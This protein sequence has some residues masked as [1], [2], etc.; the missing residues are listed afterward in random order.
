MKKSAQKQF[1]KE[2]LILIFCLILGFALRFYTFDQ[3]SLWM[4]EIYTFEDS[5]YDLKEQL[6]FYKEN[7]TYVQAPLFFILTHQLYPFEKPER[8][9]R[10]IP[11]IFG[12][13]SIPM[14]Y[15]LARQFSSTIA[16]PCSLSLALMTYHVSLSQDARSYTFLM[17]IG[18]VGLFFFM[19]HLQ[20]RAKIYLLLVALSFAILF[21]ASYSSI[22]FIAFSQILWL[23]RTDETQK[24]PPL[25]SFFTLNG[26]ILLFC[27]PWF[28]F[29]AFHYEGQPVAD[30]QN[31][32]HPL[33]LWNILYG[34]FHDWAPKTPLMVTSVILFILSVFFS[35][36][37]RNS[38]VLL[39]I[40]ILPI[41]GLYLYCR[42]FSIT[43]F[44]TSRYFITFLPLFFILIFLSLDAVETKS[45]R[46][47]K[48]LRL[49]VLFLI[50][51]I[52]T[53]LVMLPLYYRSEKQDYRGL[54]NYL[55]SRIRDGDKIIVGNV[56]YMGVVLHY[57]GVYPVGRHY[58]IPAYTV[59][60]GEVEHRMTL[61]SQ[62]IRFTII[63]S[64]SHWFEYLKDGSRLWI[65]AD[66]ENAKVIKALM[67]CPLKGYFDGSYMN[68]V[69]FPSDVSLYLFLWD[70]KFPDEKGIDIPIE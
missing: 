34:V 67:P 12:I 2:V 27:L 69:R 44:V 64:E 37:R 15:L 25:S 62:N 7:P 18:M 28:I 68:M 45:V 13:L 61:I 51:I 21:H 14:I 10:I 23:Y 24:F 26:L 52:V 20:T 65:V 8:D 6:N 63:Y 31:I 70:P 59:S 30:L 9:L 41:G 56:P 47:K 11:L 54:V 58:A 57:F 40:F 66:K 53:N 49:K 19:K 50:L 3:K 36:N 29:L 1:L 38:L 48:Y 32:K 55:K 39:S 60:N 5:R 4:D 35:K 22:P 42:L 33:S 46:L 43:H 17:F 16:L